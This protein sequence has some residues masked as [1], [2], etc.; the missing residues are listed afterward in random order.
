MQFV[1]QKQ[2]FS[3]QRDFMVQKTFYTKDGAIT[4]DLTSEEITMFANQGDVFCKQEVTKK[5][6]S[7]ATTIQ[8]QL[9]ALKKF[10]GV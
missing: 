7:Q 3:G 2:Y 10:L 5:E 8:Q 1:F 9:D 6:L 4:R